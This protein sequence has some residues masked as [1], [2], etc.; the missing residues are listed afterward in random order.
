MRLGYLLIAVVVL[1]GAASL[2]LIVRNRPRVAA[3]PFV[4][5][6]FTIETLERR[7]STGSFPNTS[8]T[9]IETR[10][11]IEY[12]VRHRGKVVMVPTGNGE[13]EGAF[14]DAR[15]LADAPRPAV[16]VGSLGVWLLTE[17]EDGQVAIATLAEPTSDFA[18]LQW[19]DVDAGQ[20]GE[21]TTLA[22]YDAPTSPRALSGGKR[23]LVNR[24]AVLDVAT[25]QVRT[26]TPSA[27]NPA[28]QGFIPSG[29]PV[30]MT[31]PDGRQVVFATSRIAGEGYDYALV[32]LDIATDQAYAVPFPRTATRFESVWDIDRAW[33][34]HYF[35]WR[36]EGD[37]VRLHYRDDVEPQPWRGRVSRTP[38][39]VEYRLHPVAPGMLDLLADFI[40]R[41]ESATRGAMDPLDRVVLRAGE[42][43]LI[44]SHDPDEQSV[45]LYVDPGPRQPS[46]WARIERIAGAFDAELATRR[47]DALFGSL[48]GAR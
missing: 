37:G 42:D 20:P 19:L 13:S 4:A 16:L 25:L 40:V 38:G 28:L 23:L 3:P 30:R 8:R 47:H 45:V 24:R 1:V 32:A 2:L 9:P 17:G 6:P 29:E 48:E 15:V 27:Y 41:T 43:V 46:G 12:A 33:L 18:T 10:P 11:L 31:S 39:M 22:M 36:P 26:I 14:W 44:L 7:I 35:D 5:G 21:E 34:A